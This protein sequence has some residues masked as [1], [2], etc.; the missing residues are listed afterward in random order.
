MHVVAIMI[1]LDLIISYFL[2]LLAPIRIG[3]EN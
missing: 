3:Y 2:G 1:L